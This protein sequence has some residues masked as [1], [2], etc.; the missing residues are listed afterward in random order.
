MSSIRTALE[1]LLSDREFRVGF[2]LLSGALIGLFQ[3]FLAFQFQWIDYVELGLS[4]GIDR[5]D[6]ALAPLY[7][8]LY[9]FFGSITVGA[10]LIIFALVR[11]L[12]KRA[13]HAGD[14]KPGPASS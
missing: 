12:T 11:V 13:Q 6:D 3:I 10:T 2:V 5:I 14:R 8:L 9:G 4:R 1:S 7:L